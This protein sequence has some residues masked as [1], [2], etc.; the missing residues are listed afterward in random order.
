MLSWTAGLPKSIFKK[1]ENW[2]IKLEI[3]FET[4]ALKPKEREITPCF[5]ICQWDV[6]YQ[7]LGHTGGWVEPPNT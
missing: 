7:E 3:A 6:C 1:N 4:S 2:V 5:G